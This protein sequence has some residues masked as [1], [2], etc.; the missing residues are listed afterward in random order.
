MF[1]RNVTDQSF[2]EIHNRESFFHICVIFMAVVVKCNRISVIVVNPG[3]GD[4]RSAKIA[5]DVFG[6]GFGIA[7]IG[8]GIDIEAVLMLGIA[9][10][11]YLFKRRSD[12]VFHFIEKSS[13]EGVTEIII[14]KVFDM[15]PESVI[16]VAAFGKKA[17]N[18]RIPFEI[19]AECMKDHDISGSV[20]FGMVQVEKHSRDHTGNGMEEAV[21]EGAILKEKIAEI[22]IYGKNAVSVLNT[23]QFKRHTGSALHRIFV[24]AGRTETA[25]TTERDKFEFS[26]M[27]TAIHCTTE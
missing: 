17:V 6:N 15:T 7:K 22:F 18:M 12:P 8:F 24:S 27:G 20:I 10:G 25:V 1:F 21:Q 5:A 2:D 13:A 9:V 14:M 23:D 4:Y 16:T 3:C 26:A 11:L 19:P